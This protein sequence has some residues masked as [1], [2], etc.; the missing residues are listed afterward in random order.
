M[1]QYM[2]FLA[3][4]VQQSDLEGLPMNTLSQGADGTVTKVL[5]LVFGIA[6]AVAVLVITVAA[7]QY[8]VSQ[9]DPQ[10][11]AKAKNTILYA[12]IGLIVC[13]LAF[14]IVTFVIDNI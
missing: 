10:A 5:Q 11:T 6:G 12:I 4:V 9:G 2:K 3:Q 8:V 13:A 7:F 1:I 14:T